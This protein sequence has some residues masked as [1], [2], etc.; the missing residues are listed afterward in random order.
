[1]QIS[2]IYIYPIKS[3]GGCSLQQSKITARGLAF[4]RRFMLTTP[5]GKFMTQR[6][7]RRMALLKTEILNNS[8]LVWDSSFP[9]S[10]IEIP[11]APQHFVKQQEVTIWKDTCMGQVLHPGINQWFSER[12]GQDCQLIYMPEESKRL[13]KT[14]YRK[15]EEIVSFADAYPI[16][17]FGQ[18]GM[19]ELNSK[20]A[21]PVSIDR[22]RANLVFTDGQPFEEDHWKSFKI[23]QQLF[24]AIKP[25]KRC[26][27]PNINQTTAKVEKEPNRTL[28]TFRRFDNHIYVGMN[29][30]WEGK[31][32]GIVKVGDNIMKIEE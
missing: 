8:L 15:G 23:G 21:Q 28:A 6:T 3:V 12:L 24:R 27:V 19:D 26:N 7:N 18:S 16:L 17:L 13:V 29:V 31:R 30:C 32:E 1:M 14:K 5:D 4:D 10:K 9:L 11:L 25:C 22:F 20:L 2:S